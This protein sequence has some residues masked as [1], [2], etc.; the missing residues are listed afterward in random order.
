MT[1]RQAGRRKASRE[2]TL[3]CRAVIRIDTKMQPIAI[4]LSMLPLFP[5]Q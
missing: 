3:F 5:L 1:A 4:V 2:D